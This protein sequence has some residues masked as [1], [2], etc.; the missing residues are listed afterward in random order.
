M[1]TD[2]LINALVADSTAAAPSPINRTVWL[3]A[4]LAVLV[5][6]VVFF[7]SLPLRDDIA[8]AL[9]T[10]RFLFKW[11]F[12]LS[13]GVS[14]L[15]AATYLMRPAG[16]QKSALMLLMVAPAVLLVGATLELF[17]LPAEQWVSTM[18]GLNSHG[19]LVTIPFLALG[20]LAVIIMSLRQ[21]APTRPAL[22]GAVAGLAATG[23]AATYYAMY[24]RDDSPLF[25]AVWYILSA[26]LVAA[27]GALAG[28]RLLR[29]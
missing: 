2:E 21:G 17:A 23:I 11:I 4:G 18:V 28:S 19:C 7:A 3:A 14:A 12:T 27:I 1:K 25:L 15:A 10:P 29:W 26:L 6:G 24:C 5:A 8:V 16:A 20:P 22:A 13:L 9:T